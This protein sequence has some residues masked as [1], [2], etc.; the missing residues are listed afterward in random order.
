MT[1][2]FPA[3]WRYLLPS[4]LF[5]AI[6]FA[7]GMLPGQETKLPTADEVR[8]LQTKYRVERDIL[9]KSGAAKRFL[10]V[11]MEKAEEIAKRADD[12]LGSGRLLQATE[13]YRQA[14]WQLPY[15]PPQ[16]PE[17]VGRILGNMRLRHN[18][19]I[20]AVAFSPDGKRLATASRDRT[21]KIWDLANGHEVLAYL[22][23]SD[24]VRSVAFSPDG[25]LI[26]SAGGEPDI[27]LWD[28]ATGK[29]VRSIKGKG[30]YVTSIAFSSDGKTLAA[31][32]DD[33]AVRLYE[34]ASGDLKREITDFRQAV[35]SVAFNA[36]SSIL[37]AGV[38]DGLIKLWEFPKVLDNAN[39]PEYWSKQDFNGSTYQVVFGPDNKTMVRVG[40]DGVKLYNTPLPGSP[41]TVT[42]HRHLIGPPDKKDRH[43]VAVFSKD[44]KTL[45]TGGTDGVIRLWDADSGLSTGTFKGHNGE[46]R[47]LTFNAAGSK[48]ASASADYTVRLWDFDIVLQARD[49]TGHEAPVWTTA[50]SPDG[51][52]V[53][54]ASA[55]KTVKVWDI[56][57][58]QVLHTLSG[59]KSGVTVALFSPDSKTILSGSGDKTLK[60]WDGNTGKHLRDL[61]GH[62]GTITSA[63]F[64]ADGGQ[65]VSAAADQRIKVWDASSGKELLSI[66]DIGDVPAA[67]A[68]SPDGKQIAAGNIDQTIRLYHA[69]SGKMLHS[70]PAHGIAVT[71]LSFSPDGKYLA[72][73]GTDHLAR[74][75]P[76]AAPGNDPI[77]LSGHSGPLSSV[78]FRKDSLHLVTGGSDQIVKL[79]KLEGSLAKEAQNFRGHKDWVTSVAFSKDGYYVASTSVDRTIKL[80]EITSREIPLL[81]EHTGAVEAV[82]VSPDGKLIASGATDKTIKIWD[83]DKGVELTTLHG[84]KGEI[85]SLAFTADSKTLV[86]SSVDR[87]IKMWDVAGGKELPGQKLHRT[88]FNGLINPVPYLVVPS[89]AKKLLAWVPGNERY[90]TITAYDLE[91]GAELFS[92]NDAGRNAL[93]VAFSRKGDFVAIGAKDGSVRIYDLEKKGQLLPGGDWFIHGKEVVLG[94]LAFTPDGQTLLVGNEA[95][96]VRICGVA[97]REVRHTVKGHKGRIGVLLT[98]P[99]GK[100]FVTAGFDNVIKLWDI[101]SGKELRTWDMQALIQ[102]RGAFVMNLTFTPDSRNLVTAN[103]NTTLYVLDLP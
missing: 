85:L 17:H 41:I 66:D 38:A 58:G 91:S 25:K 81:S 27:K 63:D 60:L 74:V 44:G 8:E 46:I 87:S 30:N 102:D 93:A 67:V 64:S 50:F 2:P 42:A 3:R 55:D 16:V 72:S 65:I 54:S 19:E 78:A 86:S 97:K 98:S 21:V 28:P 51:R 56:A 20:N 80:W 89:E 92:F 62:Q 36:D 84:H 23:H 7:S 83:R 5:T 39:Q 43:T 35:Q 45:F 13:A 4:F 10:P 103:A 32:S 9:V 61:E 76:L 79:W 14:R 59:H 68:F 96:E 57:S 40:P 69:A 26:A 18:Q 52:R 48:L 33:K 29:D 22:G 47:G 101:A 77:T 90:T 12:A 70:W 24:H 94:D 75:W 99:D 1:I 88:N 37:A 49:Y 100:R 82:A 15:Q 6:V 31:G 34:V 11:L 71:G 95:G 53:V 73:C